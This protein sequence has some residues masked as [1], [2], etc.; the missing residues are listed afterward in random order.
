MSALAN[1][2]GSLPVTTTLRYEA[3]LVSPQA[4]NGR[5]DERSTTISDF[6]LLRF[7]QDKIMNAAKRFGWPVEVIKR[8]SGD[9]GLHVLYAMLLLQVHDDRRTDTPLQ[10]C[11]SLAKDGKLSM[12]SSTALSPGL[13]FPIDLF[14]DKTEPTIGAFGALYQRS[15]IRIFVD[16]QIPAL[17]VDLESCRCPNLNFEN[18]SPTVEKLLVNKYGEVLQGEFTTPYFQRDG[19]WV[20]P[21]F[22]GMLPDSVTRRYAIEHRLCREAIVL[23]LSLRHKEQCWLSDGVRGFIKGVIYLSTS[24]SIQKTSSP[25][26]GA[27]S[28]AL[29]TCTE[30][31]IEADLTS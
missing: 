23:Q 15:P 1:L 14:D 18:A 20:T 24:A 22:S 17:A 5:N 3:N 31:Q 29:Q 19:A 21:A 8:Y 30:Q 2:S 26:V 10:I 12:S 4:S 9:R 27:E 7:H 25:R 28:A 16:E 11:L 13:L 6:Y